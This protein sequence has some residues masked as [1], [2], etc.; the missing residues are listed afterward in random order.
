MSQTIW[1]GLTILIGGTQAMQVALLG[2]MG[3]SRGPLEAAWVSILGSLAGISLALTL[4]TL[5]GA[6]PVL[7][8]P[9][10]QPLVTGALALAIG[11][12]LLTAVRGIP[13]F[14]A[15]TG[16]LPVPYLVA[17]S[18]LAPRLGVGLFLAAIVAGQLS[19]AVALDALGAFGAAPRPLDPARVAGVVALLL[20]VLLVRGVR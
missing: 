7:P 12:V 13:P 3:R 16:L 19:G 8:P 4:R 17:A 9:L 10:G 2:A 1:I 14:Y 20:G 15:T 11:S 18:F 6:R 5:S